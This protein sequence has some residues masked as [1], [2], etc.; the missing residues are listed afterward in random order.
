MRLKIEKRTTIPP[1]TRAFS[2]IL[3]I[4]VALAMSSVLFNMAGVDPL[5]AYASLF[6][7]AFGSIYG[8]SETIMKTTPLLLIGLGICIAF[9]S[10]IWNIGGEGQYLMGAIIATV[11]GVFFNSIPSPLLILT[12]ILASFFTSALWGALA[13]LL[14]AKLEV[15]EIIVTIMLN[16]IAI[17]FLYY[18]IRGP[19]KDQ[20]IV[21]G[22]PQSPPIGNSAKLPTIFPESRINLGIII[23]IAI[24]ILVYVLLFR[25][26][27]G[28]KIRIVGLNPVAANYGGISVTKITILSMFISGGLAGIA[29]AIEI[30]GVHGRLLDGIVAGYGYIGIVVALL[31][32]LHPV[33]TI[34]SAIFFGAMIVG[35][36]EMQRAIRVPLAFIQSMEGLIIILVLVTS[37]IMQYKI[38]FKKE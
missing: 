28:Y 22:F 11:I 34:L 16:Y 29:G 17:Y 31:G 30:C 5:M 18:L 8:I 26:T 33:G 19:F 12:I 21:G 4:I 6:Y 14:K 13:G 15:N 7:G 36:Q 32:E 27:L 24:A 2:M 20:T 3:A 1:I 35:M 10:K 37:L 38:T 25:T 9:R 23:A